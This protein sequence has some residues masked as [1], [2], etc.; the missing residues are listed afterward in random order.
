MVCASLI[1]SARSIDRSTSDDA[2]AVKR[3]TI[4][5]GVRSSREGLSIDP[6]DRIRK[7]T[8]SIRIISPIET[9]ECA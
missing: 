8:P 1:T 6:S 5:K 2:D 4:A 3:V 7:Q 9:V